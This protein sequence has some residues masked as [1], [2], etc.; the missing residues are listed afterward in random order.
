MLQGMSYAEND[1]SKYLQRKHDGLMGTD[2]V[3]LSEAEQEVFAHVQ[4][5]TRIGVRTT[6][7]SLAEAFEKKP[8]GWSLA[9]IQCMAAKLL[10]RGKL[11]CKIDSEP[12]EEQ[13]LER[14]LRNTQGH[15]N[16]VLEPQVEFT[17]AQVRQLKDFFN[18]FFDRSPAANEPRAL[19]QETLK[20]FTS[21]FQ[22]TLAPLAQKT[23]EY[24]FLVSLAPVAEALKGITTKPYTW[25]LTELPREADFLLD[26][27]EEVIDPIIKFMNGPQRA[28]FDEAQTYMRQQEPNLA[29][30]DGESE[31]ILT[32]LADPKC[33]K[34]S[35]MQEVKAQLNSL[36]GKITTTLQ[37]D[38]SKAVQ[39]LEVLQTKLHSTAEYAALTPQRQA[40]LNASFANA[41]ME[42]GKN[43]LIA[44]IEGT[45]RRFEDMEFPRMLSKMSE[46][47]Q[48]VQA[49]GKDNGIPGGKTSPIGGEP[50]IEYVPSRSVKVSFEKAWLA[51]ETD[52][53][54]YL[55]SMRDALLDE[56]RKGKRI[57]I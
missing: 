57:Q 45:V 23:S 41:I 46:W 32:L 18:E 43:G 34:G 26:A 2:V 15:A 38:R 11:V 49:P 17:P 27:K 30:F 52:V 47:S 39:A 22:E 3:S 4:S 20:T 54:R 10:A 7:K 44:T 31:Q 50:K 14:A 37:E 35:A 5:N 40:E 33:F 53:E 36:Q 29:Y 51:D 28:I 24:P 19:G 56:I 13:A 12:L 25:F 9:T 6:F 48:P 16:V 1:I 21:Y 55:E 8:Y 42:C